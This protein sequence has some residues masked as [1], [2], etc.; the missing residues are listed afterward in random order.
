MDEHTLPS[1]L[2]DFTCILRSHGIATVFHAGSIDPISGESA[3]KRFVSAVKY[4]GKREGLSPDCQAHIVEEI[5]DRC[6]MRRM[7]SQR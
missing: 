7:A 6:S 5:L 4:F 3:A 1:L 2:G